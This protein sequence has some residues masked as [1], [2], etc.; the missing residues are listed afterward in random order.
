M[1]EQTPK[2]PIKS[3]GQGS[4][5]IDRAQHTQGSSQPPGTSSLP[6]GASQ[7]LHNVADRAAAA[8][9]DLKDQALSTGREIKD[10]V[11]DFASTTAETVKEQA[12]EFADAAKGFV[13]QAGETLKQ[14]AYDQKDV[15][16]DYVGNLAN[17]IRRAAREFDRDLPFAAT[18]IRKAADKVEDVSDTVREGDLEDLVAG[19]QSFA[20]RQP[21][22]FLGLAVLA[23]FGAVRFLKSS[24]P[25]RNDAPQRA[26]GQTVSNTGG[27]RRQPG[28]AT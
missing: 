11:S 14:R 25:A 17:T 24:A 7:K 18:Y 10:K 13:S 2:S 1:A 4:A 28:A 3:T 6:P 23:G 9:H 5:G 26:A 20:R 16:A 22:A 8:S 21:T 12:S 27:A 15:G 19:V